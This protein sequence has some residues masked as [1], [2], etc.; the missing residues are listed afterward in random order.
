MIYYILYLQYIASCIYS[1]LLYI[2]YYIPLYFIYLLYH[3]NINCLNRIGGPEATLLIPTKNSSYVGIYT[4]LNNVS[5]FVSEESPG[6]LIT[7][8]GLI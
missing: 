7:A 5:S 8:T 6:I 3:H 1:A 4:C 2:I